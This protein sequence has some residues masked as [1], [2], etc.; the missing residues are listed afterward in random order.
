MELIHEKRV[1]KISDRTA[2]IITALLFFCGS[3]GMLLEGAV[4]K[5]SLEGKGDMTLAGAAI[6]LQMLSALSYPVGAYL[7]VKAY[8]T[9]NMRKK[10]FSRLILLAVIYEPLYDL[11]EL[12]RGAAQLYTVAIRIAIAV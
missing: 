11:L 6:A 7:T 2:V 9:D 4:Q 8:R 3:V 5:Q 10:L 1:L 12:W